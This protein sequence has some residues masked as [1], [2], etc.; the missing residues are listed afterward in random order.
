MF[1][2]VNKYCSQQVM[3]TKTKQQHIKICENMTN[4]Y[5]GQ[6]REDFYKEFSKDEIK[7]LETTL[8]HAIFNRIFN[9]KKTFIQNRL[10]ETELKK[11]LTIV[12]KIMEN[13]PD[14][15]NEKTK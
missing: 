3:P 11:S 5:K 10:S 14:K 1:L 9:F 7:Y 6:M 4:Y 15:K 8:N 12:S 2:T 13:M